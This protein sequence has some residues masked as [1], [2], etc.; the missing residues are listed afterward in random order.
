M[1]FIKLKDKSNNIIDG[2]LLIK[3]DIFNDSR[4]YFYE[5][6]NKNKFNQHNRK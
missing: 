1:E 6:W 2:P 5:T 4:G 3:Q